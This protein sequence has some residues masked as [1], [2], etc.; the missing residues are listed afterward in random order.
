MTKWA[1]PLALTRGLLIGLC[2]CWLSYTSLEGTE[3]DPSQDQ[4]RTQDGVE[5]IRLAA[6]EG[7]ASAQYNL[8]VNRLGFV[9]ELVS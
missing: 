3:R 6:E 7:H 8:G 1:T 5:A 9:R 2:L 4:T